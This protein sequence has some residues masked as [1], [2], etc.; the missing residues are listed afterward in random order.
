VSAPQAFPAAKLVLGTAQFGFDYGIANAGGT[1]TDQEVVRILELARAS[2]IRMLD[3]AIAY[4][5]SESRLGGLGLA[6][7]APM[8]KLPPLPPS[9]ADVSAWVDAQLD[10]S[11]RRLR[12]ERLAAL[13]LHRPADALGPRGPALLAALGV[14]QARGRVG[15]LGVSVYGPEELA[16]L[17][18]AFDFG[19]VQAPGNVFDRRM[20][21]SGWTHKLRARGCA[22]HLRS[23]FLQGLLLMPPATRPAWCARWPELFRGWDDCLEAAGLGAAE[24]CVRHA[25]ASGADALV[26]GVDNSAQLGAILA[27][28]GEPLDLPA[29]LAC[30]D[31][32]LVNPSRWPPPEK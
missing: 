10:G 29:A 6:G 30:D 16:P 9:I 15:L 11:L 8:S 17:F 13:S 3:T 25:L 2:G 27:I 23:C 4:G 12:V 7:L 21:A 19:L 31:P 22:L 28:P 26:V 1:P 18:E 32:D 5:S 14:Q 24:A 20:V